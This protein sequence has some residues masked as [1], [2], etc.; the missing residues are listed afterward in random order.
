MTFYGG[1][2]AYGF[3]VMAKNIAPFSSTTRSYLF[4]TSHHAHARASAS[5]IS[6]AFVI[7]QHRMAGEREI[8]QL[9]NQHRDKRILHDAVSITWRMCGN[10]HG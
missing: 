5:G 1:V 7:C 2:M 6:A 8:H 9:N 4:R 3:D 10:K